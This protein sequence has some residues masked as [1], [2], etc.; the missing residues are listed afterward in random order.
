MRLDSFLVSKG[1]FKSRNKASESISRNEIKVN[2]EV[3]TK[4]SKEVSEKDI[5]E[6]VFLKQPYVSVGGNKLERALQQFEIDVSG[7]IFADIGASTGGFTDCLLRNNAKKV[8]CVDV[9]ESLLDSK[10]KNDTRVV[11]MDKTNAR[12][13]TKNDFNDNLDGLVV[14]CSFISLEYILP[15]LVNLINENGFIVC[16]IKPQFEIG[17]KIKLKN[18]LLKQK[19]QHLLILERLY[20]F[21]L[22]LGYSV[23]NFTNAPI[24]KNKNLEFLIKV[25]KTEKGLKFENIKGIFEN[26]TK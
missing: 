13:L 16:L 21:I 24:D 20:N 18:G 5:I 12:F 11:V 26:I 2:G 9:G 25:C 22:S 7:M 15:V 14:D 4:N 19:K 17:E 23:E 6:V 10:I 3:C 1:Y 8:Y